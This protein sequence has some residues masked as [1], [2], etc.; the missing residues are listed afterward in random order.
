MS[1]DSKLF[2]MDGQGNWGY[3][4]EYM[5]SL[6]DELLWSPEN[7]KARRIPFK[8]AGDAMVY[9]KNE[10]GS[11]GCYMFG[12]ENRML[13]VGETQRDLKTR[14][15]GRYFIGKKTQYELAKKYEQQLIEKGIDGFPEEVVAEYKRQ[16][17]GSTVRL[18]GA[19]MFARI[20][21]ARVW[22]H[23]LPVD[24][25]DDVLDIERVLIHFC[26]RLNK[27]NNYPQ[28]INMEFVY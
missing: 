7:P 28:M 12:F 2:L 17:H 5:S 1:W 23:L 18:D 3:F 6:F 9:F 16:Y 20:G 10:F 25:I 26:N 24:D 11:P 13:Y 27:G 15:R 4:S 14:L 21:I 8:Y 19:V 22:F